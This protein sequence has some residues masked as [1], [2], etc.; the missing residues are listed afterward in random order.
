ASWPAISELLDMPTL[1]WR[2]L[3]VFSVG[4]TLEGATAAAVSLLLGALFLVGWHWARRVS[5]NWGSVTLIFWV[6]V[7][8]GV[9]YAIALSRPA[10]N[11]KFLLLATPA[12]YIL[13][14]RGLGQL[15]RLS[16]SPVLRP[17]SL[18]VCL[19]LV[20]VPSA[21][22]LNNYYS[23][24]AY[25]RDDYRAILGFIDS[26]A[27]DGDG[28]LVD[29]K[30]QIDVVRY[31]WRGDQSLFLLPRMRPPDV[32]ATRADVDA[33]LA[34][35]QRLFAIYYAT[36]QSDPQG[37]V[38]TRLAEKAFKARDEWHG[39]V[40]LAVY[41][42]APEA[43]EV[44]VIGAQVGSAIVLQSYALGATTLRR[45]D[46]LALTLNWRAGQVPS[47]RYKVFVHLLDVNDKVV[48][49]RDGEP[50]SDTR[51]TTTWRAGESIAD[52]YGIFID[53]TTPPG[54]FR[55]EIGMYRADDGARLP[56]VRG[57]ESISDH[58]ILGTVQVEK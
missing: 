23:N 4:L 47:S 37:I 40:R 15:S 9:M 1:L 39:N 58:L 48:A 54:D 34:K 36:D 53:A 43:R 26:N 5:A 28:I 2:V 45:G 50:V 38:E 6:L 16:S 3:N 55:I 8:V 33:M 56:I 51:L 32:T 7:P 29:D 27:R 24:P 49:Q 20:L 13:A 52:N 18:V 14:A 12:F 35:V 10:Y 11:P 42:V 44:Q 41:G 21:L 22:S 25:A 19:L 17:L 31:Y 57:G 30:G 46:I